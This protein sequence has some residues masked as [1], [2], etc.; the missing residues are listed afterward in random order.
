[1]DATGLI[2]DLKRFAVHDGPGIR[3]T[4]FLK[5][6]PLKCIWCHNPES[7]SAIPQLAY[8]ADKC[9]HC[10][11]CV[12]ICRFGAH[13]IR[14][15][16]HD[17]HSA[18]CQIC[19]ICETG[20]L[21]NALKLHGRRVSVNQALAMAE[22]DR[23]FYD[24]SGGGV[25]LSGGEPLFQPEFTFAF[26]YAL[27][28][29]AIHTALDT[30]CFTSHKNLEKILPVTDLFLV[31]FKHPDS[32]KHR[33]FTGQPN[34]RIKENLLFLSQAG[35]KIEI[36]IPLVPSC[37]DSDAEL[38]DAGRFLGD[39]KVECVKLLPYHA[40]ARTK[41][42]SL[43]MT[44]TMPHTDPPTDEQLHHA[45]GILKQFGLNARSGRE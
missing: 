15:G 45:V 41:Y 42:A 32:E 10:G 8:Y 18:K 44:D 19:G 6:C 28:N 35:A 38:E 17:F 27:K 5:G 21:G 7:I 34:E 20:C 4:F 31:D 12:N 22:E 37:N 39:L 11:E 3:T 2:L 1:M 43:G 30:S 25:T 29:A 36:R 24:E 16:K 26:L 14:D 40:L 33:K 13:E 9:I 23:S